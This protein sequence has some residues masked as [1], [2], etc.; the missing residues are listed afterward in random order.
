MRRILCL[1][2]AP[3][4]LLSCCGATL[5]LRCTLPAQDNGALSCAVPPILIMAG[6]VARRVHFAW[7]GPAAGEDS[8]SGL[9]GQTVDFT[10]SGL[11]GGTY[12]IRAWAS[13]S[14]GP[15]CDTT[16]TRSL[17]GPPHKVA[18]LP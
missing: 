10:R 3:L 15:G 4:V 16:I 12:T 2:L 1:M 6:P 5:R 7:S 17:K 14:A 8:V 9:G 18:V 11:P 13:D